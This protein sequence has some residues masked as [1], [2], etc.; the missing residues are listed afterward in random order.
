[1][2][3]PCECHE[4]IA[5]YEQQYRVYSVHCNTKLR[6]VICENRGEGNNIFQHKRPENKKKGESLFIFWV[7]PFESLAKRSIFADVI[8]KNLIVL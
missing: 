2:T 8:T 7:F 6:W 1:M 3:I 4:D 5:K